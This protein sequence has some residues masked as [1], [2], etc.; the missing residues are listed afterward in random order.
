M[1]TKKGQRRKTSRR[2]YEPKK[3]SRGN[4]P[5]R[6]GWKDQIRIDKILKKIKI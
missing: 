1:G 3:K 6:P 2:A 4:K 5:S